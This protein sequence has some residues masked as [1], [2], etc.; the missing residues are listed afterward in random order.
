MIEARTRRVYFAP[1][2][3]RHYFSKAAAISA[4][5][6]AIIQ[7]KYPTEPQESDSLGITYPGFHCTEMP[8]YGKMHHRL[9]A[10]IRLRMKTTN[11]QTP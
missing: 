2:K 8:N 10:K 11:P 3:G 1:R 5:A 7:E 4:E 6:R 9:C